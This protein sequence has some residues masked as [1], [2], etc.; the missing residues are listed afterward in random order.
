MLL[1]KWL[2]TRPTVWNIK[3]KSEVAAHLLA[4][5]TSE[6]SEDLAIAG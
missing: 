3:A 4:A 2:M 6:I 5:E 1:Y